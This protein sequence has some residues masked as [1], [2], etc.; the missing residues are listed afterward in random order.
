MAPKPR[1][2]LPGVLHNLHEAADKNEVAIHACVMMTHHVHL[3]ATQGLPHSITHMTQDLG[4]KHVH[5]IIAVRIS[6]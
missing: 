5:H 2:I 4:C 6:V 3:L 1:F